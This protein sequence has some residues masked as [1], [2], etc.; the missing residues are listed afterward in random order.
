MS[1]EGS[2]RPSQDVSVHQINDL[3]ALAR[4]KASFPKFGKIIVAEDSPI[5][6]KQIESV[7]EDCSLLESCVFC[8]DGRV[9]IDLFKKY[10]TEKHYVSHVL[11]D[12]NMP[13]ANG[14][15]VVI[16]I[17]KFIQYY[18][19]NN[20]EP[21]PKPK[22]IFILAHKSTPYQILAEELG[23]DAVMQKPLQLEELNLIL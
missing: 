21:I 12:F 18:N 23:V 3:N 20:P 11:T 17:D 5:C 4:Q 8:E 10:T 22:F 6:M 15:E 13:M 16:E 2:Q 1:S 19:R 7:L 9:A 14:R